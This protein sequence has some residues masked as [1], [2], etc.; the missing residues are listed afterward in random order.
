MSVLN[1]GI[2]GLRVAQAG[3]M[4]TS[5]NIANSSTVGY[6]RQVNIQASSLP[7]YTGYGF[8]GQGANVSSVQRVYSEYLTTQILGAEANVGELDMYLMQA[9]QI[10][11]LLADPNAGLSPALSEFFRATQQVAADPGSIPARQSM[12]SSGQALVARFQSL[13]QR[14]SEIRQGVNTQLINEV[15]V[16]NA[17][18]NQIAEL[19]DRIVRATA[20]AQGQP[21]NDL[22]DQRDQLIRQINKE[23]RVSVVPETTG[24][25]NVFIGT[26]Q[27]L[28]VGTTA[29][30]FE[31][32]G[33]STEDP[34]RITV[35]MVSPN[36]ARILIP[37]SLLQGGQ[38]GG[39]LNFRSQ[40]LDVAQNA[41]GKVAMAVGM[42]FN[43]QHRL[44]IDL[45]GMAGLDM[46]VVPQPQVLA[47][48]KNTSGANITAQII[49]SDYKI[50][51]GAGTITRLSDGLVGAIGATP[52][53]DGLTINLTSGA[54]G[55]TDVFIIKPGNPPAQ[56]VFGQSDNTGNAVYNVV[57]TNLQSLP[58]IASDYRLSVLDGAGTLSL[59]RL[60]DN[61]V[62]TATDMADLQT[63]L[64]QDPQGFLI[65]WFGTPPVPPS[66]PV[67]GESFLIMPTRNAA[68]NMSV[69]ISDAV[70]VAAAAPFRTESSLT[71][72]GSGKID[73]G[74]LL[75][76]DPTRVPVIGAVT[77]TYDATANSLELTGGIT[78]TIPNFVPGQPNVLVIN[79]MRFTISGTPAD[80]DTFLI[81]ANLNGVSDN[82]N[83]IALG[84]LQG[85]AVLGNGSATYQSAYG[86]IVSFVG[87]KTREA[88]VTGMAQQTLA[89]QGEMARQQLSGVNLD[90]EAANLLKF[91]QAYQ[92]SAKIMEIAGRMFDELLALGR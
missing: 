71:N 15:S 1:I 65:D 69:A 90:E 4:T 66:P 77:I 9:R 91:Q 45:Q 22:L 2:T 20:I 16:I 50:D 28:V 54:P 64:A 62:W 81:E 82:R 43:S 40:T 83:V 35:S 25:Y 85:K 78:T 30:Q 52:P 17:Y 11:N 32:G 49:D 38:L 88:E 33:V 63:K 84:N 68:K 55:G 70:K 21:P 80:G 73:T 47:N 57:G 87:N 37:E 51:F 27:P 26:G 53:F 18:A 89:D 67:P 5:H 72:K 79:G 7:N 76:L 3:L 61:K 74:S 56:R 75:A 6:N 34:E 8:V 14:M 42:T 13:D 44:G 23:I 60:A 59:V 58:T 29:F 39:L 92:A 46:F 41:L 10:D 19:N 31:A 36:G 24:S 86:Q 12:L 48:A